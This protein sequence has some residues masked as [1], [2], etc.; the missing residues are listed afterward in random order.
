MT[1]RKVLIVGGGTAG[2]MTAAHLNAVLNREGRD[3]VRISLIESPDEPVSS[4]G[5][6]TLPS[7]NQFL[8]ILGMNQREF[9]QRVDGTL[10]QSTKF[11]NWLHNE[12]DHFHHPFSMERTGTVDRSAERWLRS[13]RSVPFAE[14]VS[15]QPALCEMDLAPLMQSRWDFGSP[16]RYAFHVDEAKCADYLREHST[17]RGVTRYADQV[18]GVERD[19]KGD[20]ATVQ[21][22]GGQRLEADLYVDCSGAMA[23]LS[24][25][26]MGIGWV[27]CSEW[28][29]CD[30]ALTLTVPYEQYYPGFV[31]P[32]TTATA[33]SGGW[34]W[35][36]PL[37]GSRS[38]G[39][40][41]S[42]AFVSEEAAE[43]ELRAFEGAHAE[44]LSSRLVHYKTGHRENA[45][46]GNCVSIG[47]A[48]SFI[49]SL[50]A[51]SLYMIDLAVEMLVDHFPYSDNMAPLA[52]RYNRIMINRY[53]ET[54]DFVN[55]HY[56]LTRRN[57]S[58]FWREVQRPE[59]INDR[60]RAKLDYWRLK[61]PTPRDFEDQFFPGQPDT[62]LRS[63]VASGDYRS[64]ID[65]AGLWDHENYEAVLYGMQFLDEECDER[66]GPERHDSSVARHV[67][68]RLSIAPQKLPPHDVWLKQFC[69]MSDYL[70]GARSSKQ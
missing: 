69:G 67:L 15:P 3:V 46:V 37:L 35:D 8:A 33:L 34:A 59:R 28:L 40:V 45:W 30:R 5:E 49:E 62:P 64:P 16:L 43:Q 7:I 38:L 52:Y 4:V 29:L 25:Q 26:A 44:S 61:R 53:Y 51:T 10:K 55:L 65:T 24:E 12:G 63:G 56:C 13:N 70:V 47:A 22:E 20:I 27:D 32:F 21:I 6:T 39:Y 60:L 17:A 19:E 31:H 68:E 41:H 42:S 50:E 14:T 66:F 36:I 9:M 1:P 11:V 58:E 54:L 57:D 2:W 18:A 48:S 23:L